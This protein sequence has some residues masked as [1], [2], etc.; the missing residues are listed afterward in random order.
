MNL[1]KLRQLILENQKRVLLLL[2]VV[3]SIIITFS[4][5]N[6]WFTR[7]NTVFGKLERPKLVSTIEGQPIWN[8][9]QIKI[10]NYSRAEVFQVEKRAVSEAES[11]ALASR[12][13]FGDKPKE[14]K[15][16]GGSL[17]HYQSFNKILDI[18]ASAG[19]ISFKDANKIKAIFAK[20]LNKRIN[21]VQATEKAKNFLNSL[22]LFY[23][24]K[25]V[26]LEVSNVLY[27]NPPKGTLDI[28]HYGTTADDATVV[29][30]S[31]QKKVA[32]L[33]IRLQGGSDEVSVTVTRNDEVSGFFLNNL[34]VKSLSARYPLKKDGEV[35]KQLLAGKGTLVGYVNQS[36]D[37]GG[38]VEANPTSVFIQTGQLAYYN[39]LETG[40]LQP[41]FEFS[42]Q[43]VKNN[44][45]YEA[46]VDLPAVDS[47]Y[48]K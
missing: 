11:K 15:T 19:T 31:F 41:V 14:V 40:Y 22:G 18:V 27:F 17:W 25:P 33:P 9:S 21:L 30:I 36:Q 42:A 32:G 24:D 7:I 20:N 4:L 45:F 3:G 16:P 6:W 1:D 43:A 35:R 47:K 29:S 5:I 46:L 13:G 34:K 39:D 37:G 8:L 44:R 38:F 12:L 23:A 28:S 2:V 26:S 10:P 48:F